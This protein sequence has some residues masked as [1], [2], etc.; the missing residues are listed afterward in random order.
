[1]KCVLDASITV[2][3]VL[4]D[5]F[6]ADSERALLAIAADGAVVPSLWEFEVLNALR[7]A[8]KR[9]RITEAGLANALNGL[10]GLRI[11]SF[12]NPVDRPQLL[13]LGVYDATYAWVA[14]ESNLPLATRD[15]RLAHAASSMGI[16]LV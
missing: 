8:E 2:S 6:T 1:M 15:A 11:E 7:S 5:E 4:A 13:S 14:L 3:F 12:R 16:T 9:G 10:A